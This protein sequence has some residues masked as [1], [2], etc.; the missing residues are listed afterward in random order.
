MEQQKADLIIH[1][2]GL[3]ILRLLQRGTMTADEIK[4][5]LSDIPQINLF[6]H[7]NRLVEKKILLITRERSNDGSI[8]RIYKISSEASS[9]IEK[10]E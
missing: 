10:F 4:K 8:K 1:S 2:T 3:R 5:A 7:I 9:Q 6:R